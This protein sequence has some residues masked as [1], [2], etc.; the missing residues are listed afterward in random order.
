MLI[1]IKL[2]NVSLTVHHNAAPTIAAASYAT[3]IPISVAPEIAERIIR[4][5]VEQELFVPKVGNSG[6]DKGVLGG[7]NIDIA[8]GTYSF[9]VEREPRTLRKEFDFDYNF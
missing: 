3:E 6:K 1:R 9:F 8:S 4:D 2:S 7:L 5:F